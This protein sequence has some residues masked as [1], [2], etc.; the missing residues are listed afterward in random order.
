MAKSPPAKKNIC[1]IKRYF[2]DVF[3]WV[4]ALMQTVIISSTENTERIDKVLDDN[5]SGITVVNIAPT[6]HSA[7]TLRHILYVFG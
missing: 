3:P 6:M 5:S 7:I 2:A 4:I 1:A